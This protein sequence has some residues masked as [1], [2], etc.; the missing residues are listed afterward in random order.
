MNG[1]CGNSFIEFPLER[2]AITIDAEQAKIIS[3]RT[4]VRDVIICPFIM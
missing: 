2:F 4:Y 1:R 3:Y